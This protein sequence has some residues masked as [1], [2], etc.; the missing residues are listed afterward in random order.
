M[1]KR[2]YYLDQNKKVQYSIYKNLVR[3]I[4]LF[5][6]LK[7]DTI[8]EGNWYGNNTISK[9]IVDIN[10]ILMYADKDGKEIICYFYRLFLW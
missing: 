2:N 7:R 9:T 10:K 5:N 3:V 8:E 1:D 6:K 4:S